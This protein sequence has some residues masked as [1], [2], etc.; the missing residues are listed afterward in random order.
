MANKPWEKGIQNIAQAEHIS[1]EKTG[2]NIEAKKVANYVFNPSTLEWQRD[3]GNIETPP[4]DPSKNNPSYLLS[5]NAADELVYADEIIG[6]DT[7]RTTFTRSDMTITS[8]LP[9][10]EAIKQ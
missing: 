7:Y 6:A 3:S 2:D 4:T 10:S 8:T 1:P 9:I 5:F